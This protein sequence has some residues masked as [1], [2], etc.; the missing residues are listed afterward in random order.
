MS[1]TRRTFLI[2]LVVVPLTC[3]L[4]MG[5]FHVG[6]RLFVEYAN[7]KFAR[8]ISLG[9]PPDKAISIAALVA[10][11]DD[12]NVQVFVATT[13]GRIYQQSTAEQK[14]WVEANLPDH[15]SYGAGHNCD[16]VPHA[17]FNSYFGSLPANAVECA[18]MMWNWEWFA[19]ETF[20]VLLEDGSLWWWHYSTRF[21]KEALFLFCGS[22]IGASLVLVPFSVLWRR[23]L[24]T[25]T[26]SQ[27]N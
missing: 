25:S 7:G 19:D 17:A 21:D 15:L 6:G 27:Q 4:S 10:D 8:W 11:T 14:G 23:R 12:V 3:S 20:C 5:G 2:F 18:T 9:S 1:T 22:V 24:R 26:R 16:G 13:S